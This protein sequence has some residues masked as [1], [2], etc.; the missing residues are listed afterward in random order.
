LY[1]IVLPITVRS[2]AKALVSRETSSAPACTREECP[3]R[4]ANSALPTLA[5]IGGEIEM[6]RVKI[7]QTCSEMQDEFEIPIAKADAVLAKR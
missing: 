1:R 6:L 2:S 7:R 5:Q 3:I 4:K